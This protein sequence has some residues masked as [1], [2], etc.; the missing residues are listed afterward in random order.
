VAG[1]I[2]TG[3]RNLAAKIQDPFTL[4]L[5][6]LPAEKGLSL[7]RTAQQTRRGR[8][9]GLRR[10]LADP[11]RTAR[12]FNVAGTGRLRHLR[13]DAWI[14]TQRTRGAFLSATGIR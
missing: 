11:H 9:G 12:R 8:T 4:G 14:A 13:D 1:R 3:P 6:H 7:R 2:A 5:W 10:D